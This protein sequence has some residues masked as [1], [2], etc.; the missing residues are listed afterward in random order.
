MAIP[1]NF[2][3]GI[4]FPGFFLKAAD[5]N[6][7]VIDIQERSAVF[8]LGYR[9]KRLLTDRWGVTRI[10]LRFAFRIHSVADP[11]VSW[12]MVT[13]PWRSPPSLYSS[14]EIERVG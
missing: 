3:F 11:F 14:H 2:G 6:H 1:T 7:L 4:H 12:A 9:G 8:P 10:R 5:K 13:T